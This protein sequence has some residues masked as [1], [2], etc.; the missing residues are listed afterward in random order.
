[1]RY[2]VQVLLPVFWFPAIRTKFKRWNQK[3]IHY[4]SNYTYRTSFIVEKLSLSLYHPQI[5]SSWKASP[6]FLHVLLNRFE[7]VLL[8]VFVSGIPALV[9]NIVV[10]FIDTAFATWRCSKTGWISLSRNG[11]HGPSRILRSFQQQITTTHNHPTTQQQ[12]PS[13]LEALLLLRAQER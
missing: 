9:A 4:T 10:S 6:S 12:H 13:H 11:Y 8:T 7:S 1:M 3:N 5:K 2:L